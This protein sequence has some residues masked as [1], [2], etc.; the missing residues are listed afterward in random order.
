[1]IQGTQ[2]IFIIQ[3]LVHIISVFR[4]RQENII[5][6]KYNGKNGEQ[7]IALRNSNIL[8]VVKTSTEE[9]EVEII[10]ECGIRNQEVV[11]KW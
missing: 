9:L 3:P 11:N 1:M 7:E 6:I 10:S 4:E 8:T 2:E 5:S